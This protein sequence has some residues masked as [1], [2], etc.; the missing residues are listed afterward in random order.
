M[1]NHGGEVLSR[2]GEVLNHDGIGGRTGYTFYTEEKDNNCDYQ[3][4]GVTGIF[5]TG[6]VPKRYYGRIEEIWELNYVTVK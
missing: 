6:E 1:L 4:S 2:G 3:N 5:Y